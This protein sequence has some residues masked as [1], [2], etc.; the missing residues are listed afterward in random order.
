MNTT[1][2]TWFTGVLSACACVL[3]M[4]AQADL[5][6]DVLSRGVL[7]VAIPTDYAPYGFVG[8]DMKPQ[9]LDIDM[10]NLVAEKLGVKAELVP[11]TTPNRIPSLRTGKVDIVISTLGKTEERAQV[12]DF[13]M[14]YAPFFDAVF[15]PKALEVKTFDDLAGKTVAVMRSSMH[16]QELQELAP[17]AIIRRY[18]DANSTISAFLAGHTELV[19]EGPPAV[20]ALKQRN[21]SLDIELKLILSNAPNYIGLMKGNPRLLERLNAII[22]ETKQNGKLDEISIRWIGAPAG[23]LPE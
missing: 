11:T 21:P 1:M 9:G 16:D 5:L 12:I 10:A 8:P 19:G 7:R 20:A 2:R 14:A 4:P 6:D 22:R 23:E 13:T 3:T 18:E 17:K 15:G